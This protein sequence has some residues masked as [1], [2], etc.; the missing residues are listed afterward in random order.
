MCDSVKLY[1][2]LNGT[3]P[4]FAIIFL[5]YV[6]RLQVANAPFQALGGGR[7]HAKSQR[8]I[9]RFRFGSGDLYRRRRVRRIRPGR[10]HVVSAATRIDPAT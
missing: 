6:E 1:V 3:P 2:S 5:T 8:Q 4:P 10:N 7:Q 9:D